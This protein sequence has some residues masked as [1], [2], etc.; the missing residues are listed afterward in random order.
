MVDE[1]C[2]ICCLGSAELGK[3]LRVGME[4]I[5]ITAQLSL[6]TNS[7]WTETPD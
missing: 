6:L 4:N 2:V 5:A 7:L 1:K 3:G